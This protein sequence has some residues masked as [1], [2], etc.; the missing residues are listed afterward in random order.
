MKK[1]LFVLA[2]SLFTYSSYAQESSDDLK[3]PE[4]TTYYL[5]RHAEKQRQNPDDKNPSLTFQGY[6]RADKWRDIFRYV[7]LNAIY[8]TD[9]NRT[10]QTAKPTADSKK[11]PILMY[12]PSKMYTESFQYNTKGKNVLIV[13]HSNTTPSFVNKIL[14]INKYKQIDDDNNANLYIVK[15][16]DGKASASV[17]RID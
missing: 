16:I 3:K 17:L 5:I 4:V 1:F 15:V 2:L 6:K 7:P 10:K 9:Y 8:S 11:L 13:G 12:D 14:G